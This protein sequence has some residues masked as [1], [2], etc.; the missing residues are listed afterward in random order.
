MKELDIICL[1]MWK[2]SQ[3]LTGKNMYEL[4]FYINHSNRY[5]NQQRIPPSYK[6][7]TVAANGVFLSE[8]VFLEI[9]KIHRKTPVPQSLLIKLQF[10]FY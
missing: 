1:L 3:N 6:T 7:P 4:K 8:K 5:C 9:C 10:W 2:I